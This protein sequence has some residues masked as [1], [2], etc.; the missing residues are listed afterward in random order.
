MGTRAF[1]DFDEIDKLL[2]ES[3]E[4]YYTIGESNISDDVFDQLARES[5]RSK[6]GFISEMNEED[7]PLHMGSLKY[8]KD[9]AH[10]FFD[11]L[12]SVI[13]DKLDGIAILLEFTSGVLTGAWKRGDHDKGL[14]VTMHM[15]LCQCPTQFDIMHMEP[16]RLEA[17][18]GVDVFSEGFKCYAKCEAVVSQAIF[19]RKW[20]RDVI[21]KDGFAS[22]RSFVAGL[23]ARKTV[24][25]GLNDIDIVC[26]DFVD[27]NDE[28][29]G[30]SWIHSIKAYSGLSKGAV[31]N[32]QPVRSSL[33]ILF[34]TRKEKSIYDLDGLVVKYNQA[35][36]RENSEW[37]NGCP[38]Y[39]MAFKGPDEDAVTT[40]TSIFYDVGRTGS[41]NPVIW[42]EPVMLLGTE[43]KKATGHN[44]SYMEEHGIGEGA[45]IVVS[46]HGTVIP[47]H[48]S[49]IIKVQVQ[50]LE[51]CPS[52]FGS[53][54]KVGDDYYCDRA[55]A[56]IEG[57]SLIGCRDSFVQRL[58]Y[59]YKMLGLEDVATATWTSWSQY[60]TN[61]Y[62]SRDITVLT[63]FKLS[64]AEWCRI[65]GL[66]QVSALNIWRQLLDIRKSV[67]PIYKFVTA[68]GYP[69][70]GEDTLFRIL[71]AIPDL[72]H[73]KVITHDIENRLKAIKQIGPETVA[74][75]KKYFYQI[76]KYFEEYETYYQIE[77]WG[78]PTGVEISSKKLE[79]VVYYFTGFRDIELKHFVERHSA[80]VRKGYS[81]REVT[82][83]VR[84]DS[85]YVSNKVKGAELIESQEIITCGELIK[86]MISIG[87]EV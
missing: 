20:H 4:E 63:P 58:D 65:D 46:K 59:C 54:T 53:I 42:Y 76:K 83:L 70:L 22:P 86:R 55:V 49:T 56:D 27:S 9:P 18:M 78:S 48:D 5:G 72:F 69:G 60:T 15:Q 6:V 24:C 40:I 3:A 82:C 1:D 85:S 50:E 87:Y 79:G 81:K 75:L 17:L 84:F 67:I 62:F 19:M 43:C 47:N 32:Y 66:G 25:A 44:Q 74:I 7:L 73:R 10:K 36:D 39:A 33:D 35:I 28:V 31:V 41:I 77:E 30:T 8:T 68:L 45:K 64:E 37:S 61:L 13:T 38:G 71:K 34:E 57:D 23:M 26:H 21:G 2:D 51:M 12:H 11:W 52:C 29:F 14:N 16:G 80:I